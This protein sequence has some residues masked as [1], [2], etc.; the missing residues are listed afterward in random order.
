MTE[1]LL[2]LFP[3][4]ISVR[5]PLADSLYSLSYVYFALLG[6]LTTIASGLLVSISTGETLFPNYLMRQHINLWFECRIKVYQATVFRL[7]YQ[8]L[9]GGLKQE[10]LNSDLFVTKNDLKC[11]SWCSKSEVRLILLCAN[12]V[13]IC[14]V[15]NSLLNCFHR[16][17]TSKKRQ[18]FIWEKKTHHSQ[19]L[20]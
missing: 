5:P 6:T 7:W 8:L 17:Q 13:R 18:T 19:I 2:R 9:Q 12:K 4:S 14:F 3:L 15:T 20:T 10:K 16:N 1:G 11:F